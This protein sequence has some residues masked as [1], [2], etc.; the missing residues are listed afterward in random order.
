[1]QRLFRMSLLVVLFGIL[2][3]SEGFAQK[4]Q[5]YVSGRVAPGEVRVF[6][7]DSV[8]IVHRDYMIGGTLIIEPGTKVLFHPNGRLIDSTGG[9]IIADGSANADYKADAGTGLNPLATGNSYYGYA[10]PAYFL[11]NGVITLNTTR[12]RT[13]HSDKSHY[14]Y[15]V[16]LDTANRRLVDM[17]DP[18][19]LN[20]YELALKSAA[21]YNSDL[22]VVS[23]EHAI[24]WTAARLE[25][26]RETDVNLNVRPWQRVNNSSDPDVIG[27][28]EASRIRFVGQPVNNY[29]REWGHIVILPGARAAFFRN[30]TFENF[31]KDITVDRAPFFKDA[32]WLST[33]ALKTLN[34]K[35]NYLTNGSGG[36]LTTFSSRTWVINAIFKDN[37]A[38]LRG[39]ALQILQSPNGF[40][41]ANISL[42]FYPLDKNPAI[43]DADRSSSQVLED[44]PVLRIDNIDEPIAVYPEPL[45]DF[46][47]MAY[48]DAR[49]AVYLGRF[50]NMIFENNKA[51]LA[52]VDT[53]DHNSGVRF[54]TDAVMEYLK[55]APY[56][57]PYGN[58]AYGGAIYIA[59][60]DNQKDRKIEIGFG[61]NN[62]IR[63]SEGEIP[64]YSTGMDKFEAKENSAKNYQ[65]NNYSDGA[66][67]G[68][69]Y[70]GEYTSLILSGALTDNF[71]YARYFEDSE[72]ANFPENYS[73]AI[74]ASYSMGG[75]VF[76]ANTYGRLQFRGGPSRV[77]ENETYIK[78]NKSGAGG[79]VFVDGN[80]SRIKSPII[81]GTDSFLETRDWGFD[82][83]F[84]D[85]HAVA[86]GGAIYTTRSMT[87]NGSGGV[88]AGALLGYGGKYPVKFYDNTA[89]F[90]GGALAVVI[91][92]ANPPLPAEDRTVQIVRAEFVSNVVGEKYY[93]NADYRDEARTVRGGGAIYSLQGDLNVIKGVEFRQ[94]KT[95][96]GNGGAIAMVHPSTS[97]KRF[98]LT[99]LDQ[100]D[101]ASTG[102]ASGYTSTNDVFTMGI[103][104]LPA[105]LRMLTRFTDNVAEVDS[106]ILAELS[107]TG[108]TQVEKGTP[109]TTENIL[110]TYWVDGNTGYAVGLNGLVIKLTAG[111]TIWQ[112]MTIPQE[113]STYRLEDITF[114]GN[115]VGYIAGDRGLILK[116]TDAGNTW[117]ALNTGINNKSVNAID[118]V[119]TST[120]Y[121]A[122][123]G[124]YALKT[125][126]AGATWTMLQPTTHNLNGVFFTGT[127]TGYFVGDNG[128]L[129]TTNNGGTSWNFP[130]ITGLN[131]NLHDVYF[132]TTSNGYAVGDAGTILRTTNGGGAWT[133][134]DAGTNNSIFAVNFTSTSIGYAVGQFG[135]ALKTVDGG[136][137]WTDLETKDANNPNDNTNQYTFY[138]VNFAS[139]STGTLVGQVGLI[140][141]TEN[142]GTSWINIKPADKGFR[143]VVR[144]HPGINL[145]ENGVGLG[146][147]LYIL[148]SVNVNRVGRQDTIRFNRVRI[149]DNKAY[150]G[151]AVYSDNFDLKLIFNRSL[152]NGNMAWSEVDQNADGKSQNVITGPMLNSFNPA[153]SDLAGATIYGEIQGPL[154][155]F[156]FSEG[157]N[158]IYDN[159][160][161]FLI[162]L[163]DAPNTKGILAGGSG[164]GYGGT[165]TLRG[166]YWGKT[167]ANIIF[168]VPS[169]QGAPQ[170]A[171]IETFWVKADPDTTWMRF[172]QRDLY[173]D[174]REQG[175]FESYGLPYKIN[176]PYPEYTVIP[177]VNGATQFEVGP[178]SIPEMLLMSGNVYDLY[179]KGTDVKTADYS[180][181]RMSPIEDFA[182]GIPPVLR[183]YDEIGVPSYGK[184]IKR[185]VRDPFIAEMKDA[186][187]NLVYPEIA[188][189]QT[190]FK[191]DILGEYYHPIG[192][193][194]YLESVVNY[195]GLEERSNHDERMLNQ[196]VFFV[197]NETTGDYIR[198]NFDQVD[199]VAPY[200]EVFR[201]TVELV[202][203]LTSR[204]P[205]TLL[206]RTAE[207]LTNFGSGKFLLEQ[208]IHNAYNEDA[209][210]LQGRKYSEVYNKDNTANQK[211]GNVTNL[212]SNRPGLPDA[213]IINARDK[214]A[215][216]FGGERYNALPV[217][218]GDIV[219]IVS[220][221]VLWREGVI[222]AYED[223]I[224]FKVTESTAPPVFTGDIPKLDSLEIVKIVPSEFPW[225]D[226][227]TLRITEFSDKIFVSED[228]V[229]PAPNGKYSNL[230]VFGGNDEIA[231]S[232][233]RDSI[234]NVTAI[235][236]NR[237][238]DPLH[239]AFPTDYSELEYGWSVEPGSGLS[240]WLQVD[241]IP[242][243]TNGNV[244]EKDGAR[245]YIQFKGVPVNPFVVP[246]GET[247]NVSARNFPPHWRVIDR[248]R[249]N[250]LREDLI[251]Q[252]VETYPSY[253]FAGLYDTENARH[254]QQDTIDYG[255]TYMREYQFKLFVV[256]S[257]PR[258][259]EYND[260][261]D[262]ESIAE[263]GDVTV[264]YQA[265]D[266]LCG[267]NRNNKIIA[268][269]TDK[270]RFQVD[271][272]TDDEMEDKAFEDKWDFRYGR[273]AYGFANTSLY[274]VDGDTVVVDSM[275]Y[276]QDD[277]SEG[278]N[279]LVQVRP[280][281]MMNDYIYQG[282]EYEGNNNETIL[283]G[284][285]NAAYTDSYLSDF[286][287][288]GK[289]NIRMP[290][291]T[292][293]KYLT[294]KASETGFT[295]LATDTV[296]AI[297]VND[298]HGSVAY[299][300]Y[301]VF[302][303]FQPQITGDV[304]DEGNLILPDA[305]EGFDYNPQL[306]NQQRMI[307]FTDPNVDQQHYFE[308]VYGNDTRDEIRIDPCFPEAGVFNLTGLKTTPEW[309]KID[310]E[311]GKLYGTPSVTDSP[312][313]ELVTVVIRDEDGLVDVQKFKLTVF[314]LLNNNP[315]L[316]GGGSIVCYETGADTIAI[317]SV[318]DKDLLRGGES[319]TFRVLDGNGSVINGMT[320]QPTTINT[321]GEETRTVFVINNGADLEVGPDGRKVILLEVSDSY[322]GNIN[323][324]TLYIQIQKSLPTL[325]T[326]DLYVTN[327]L[328]ATE[329]LEFGI[330]EGPDVSTGDG[331]VDPDADRTGEI[332]NEYCEFEL[333]PL[334][335]DDVFD[336]RWTI[337]TK[338]GILR[339][340]YPDN[341]TAEGKQLIFKG[342][343]QAGGVTGGSGALY[344]VTIS[345]RPEDV[346]ST[347]DNVRNPSGSSF[348]IRDS[349]SNGN[350]FSVNMNDVTDRKSISVVETKWDAANEYF[351]VVINES[352]I[353]AFIIYY[354]YQTS[355]EDNAGFAESTLQQV[356]PNPMTNTTNINF[357]VKEASNVKIEVIDNLG[358]VVNVLT[359]AVYNVGQYT[360]SWIGTSDT[361]EQLANGRYT[362]RMVAGTNTSTLPVVIVK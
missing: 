281:W 80:V 340:I 339:N 178:L 151:S 271:I 217:N 269:V 230:T 89:G 50:R 356:S 204:A 338:N 106:Y 297:A 100:V 27:N 115:G 195:D 158:S 58:V 96:N 159:D 279:T 355:V 167:E 236:T 81:G 133:F 348:Y 52:T 145:P 182:V 128:T 79:A 47:R 343:I 274:P 16:L 213:N 107:G 86:F 349:Y 134:A 253:M 139:Q 62:F 229:Y 237:F 337:P 59:G 308:L 73:G 332:D 306:L 130:P 248:M 94:N 200:R 21:K 124:G 129:V 318:T 8:Y 109:V 284:E 51:Q 359:N 121:A 323:R 39:G 15:N 175:P 114:T 257:L 68:A 169:L 222:P 180:K 37:I 61:I 191:A 187:G 283:Y 252:F 72:H 65:N 354:D 353:D 112:Y 163:P 162:R 311:S 285:E 174:P 247:V 201:K 33:T 194:L 188:A 350:L 233:G 245:G 265:T 153:S 12:D 131:T 268:N 328:G 286:T 327:A 56:P 138:D 98:F 5:V 232:Q 272:N 221:T 199:E 149:Q 75:A 46:D 141:R 266:Y 13:V 170:L 216:Y 31:K 267:V 150:T 242:H 251:D 335:P 9:R 77:S 333:P 260:A 157:A 231:G 320:T 235:D 57:V 203:D 41:K 69:I 83:I 330:A 32:P 143:D 119:G 288:Y 212:F 342:T 17:P 298:G 211:L 22:V 3:M 91:P 99:D 55:P 44:S 240:Y 166:N 29:S 76:Q 71:T 243:T 205:N 189:L 168:Q 160:A 317:V 292:A 113:Y 227:D 6:L 223:G 104:D 291:D 45:S 137:N 301:P 20:K 207:G 24:L 54:V 126:D 67:G 276:D 122:L 346:P 228:R 290:K 305:F 63:T 197:I 7:K 270:L 125:T 74:S 186:G 273:T 28:T 156:I 220:R 85:N 181:R 319:L 219:R 275:Y 38:R 294:S 127:E 314:G 120:G 35:F 246:G 302:V 190:E 249:E 118:F 87:I 262:P 331:T 177:L 152:I 234:L 244:N 19:D 341:K 135:T 345:W 154:P 280:R 176:Q 48:D 208:L 60:A 43:T 78:G 1:M 282:F 105:D 241:T 172:I 296:F 289:L 111:G 334:P 165:D 303:N 351:K 218:A 210:A 347:T 161:R 93:D 358:N 18:G 192:Y 309:L 357:N 258:F 23:Y 185:F 264:V 148:D 173:A 147:A 49:I 352:S 4:P 361:G 307:Q 310:S 103:S 88:E 34:D 293:E 146:G 36:A 110:G 10:D 295:Y 304:D 30:V 224:S 184:Y 97:S 206:R 278:A 193:P 123:D 326:A 322:G 66:R 202:P 325:F 179:D 321:Q 116:T 95:Y 261:P 144:E 315:Q 312:A 101:F 362:I 198:A 255:K 82:V 183:R 142:S 11:A 196:S 329:V 26:D 155:S 360:I 300:K 256:D 2:A 313:N 287:V 344:P 102:L 324:D 132:T 70:V 42:G 136:V 140:K 117:F 40:P 277:F 64:L 263:Y 90:A 259:L 14:V 336:A 25:K 250:G 53:V 299:K 164:I 225:K 108:A 239:Q 238:Y 226:F 215:T 214:S 209:G 316:D 254:L 84:Q 171:N 92:N